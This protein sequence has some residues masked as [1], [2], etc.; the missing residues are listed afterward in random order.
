M[1]K[2]YNLFEQVILESISRDKIF[3]C[4]IHKYRV[5]ITYAGEDGDRATGKRTIE[6]YAYGTTQNGYPVIRAYQIF[7][8]TKTK[9]PAWKFFRLDRILSWEPTNFYFYTP[10]SDRDSTIPP[11][12]EDGED[13]TMK[14]KPIA[15]AQF[16]PQ[17]RKN[18]I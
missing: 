6:V 3:D 14:L 7:G 5:N 13:D 18:K 16:D 1:L 4:L 17:Y 2:L 9:K 8:E 12:R 11:Y 15:T 10:I